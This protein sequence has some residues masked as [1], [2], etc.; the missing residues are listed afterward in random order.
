MATKYRLSIGVQPPKDELA[1]HLGVPDPLAALWLTVRRE[2]RRGR[3][4]AAQAAVWGD[5]DNPTTALQIRH[6]DDLLGVNALLVR[7]AG[8]LELAYREFAAARS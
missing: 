2:G 6:P 1:A 3:A 4:L 5:P 8:R 7:E